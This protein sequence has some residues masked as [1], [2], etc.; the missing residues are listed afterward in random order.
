METIN[1][2]LYDYIVKKCLKF[3]EI[4]NEELKKIYIRITLELKLEKFDYKGMFK[5]MIE[6]EYISGFERLYKY[7]KERFEEIFE[8]YYDMTNLVEKEKYRMVRWLYKRFGINKLSNWKAPEITYY[9]VEKDKYEIIREIYK[10]YKEEGILKY[11]VKEYTI[12]LLLEKRKYG[13]IKWLYKKSIKDGWKMDKKNLEKILEDGNS[14]MIKWCDEKKIIEDYKGVVKGGARKGNI[15]ILEWVWKRYEGKK[16]F[17]EEEIIENAI[18]GGHLSVLEWYYGKVNKCCFKKE[19]IN[20]I[21]KNKNNRIEILEWI[22]KKNGEIEYDEETIDIALRNENVEILKFF[23]YKY[24]ECIY[25][26][27]NFSGLYQDYDADFTYWLY[28]EFGFKTEYLDCIDF[29]DNNTI[30]EMKNKYTWG[31]CYDYYPDGMKIENCEDEDEY[32]YEYDE[33]DE[34]F[35][36]DNPPEDT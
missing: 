26:K 17:P 30:I 16:E 14:G 28:I 32:E 5:Y 33:D 24:G 13:M 34:D 22:Y 1:E 29:E 18:E 20:N 12:K 27:E 7:D 19:D 2:P 6:K 35:D 9:L 25:D 23:Y 36:Y 10:K 15:E 11:K 21:A 4:K 3:E 8:H 31:L